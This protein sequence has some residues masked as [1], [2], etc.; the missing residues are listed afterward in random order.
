MKKLNSIIYGKLMLQA[1]E[2]RDRDMLKLAS[3]I[4]ASVE[5]GPDDSKIEYS[6]EDLN[7]DIQEG[8][9]KLAACVMKYHD[10]QS[11]DVEKMDDCLKL[12]GMTVRSMACTAIDLA[13]DDVGPLE[14]K[15]LGESK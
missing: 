4:L 9:W 14:P 11:V 10:I 13:Y 5:L 3:D 15:V 12:A 6:S 7:N 1:E 2:A 8:L